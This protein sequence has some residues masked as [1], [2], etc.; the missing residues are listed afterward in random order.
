MALDG[1]Y[2]LVLLKYNDSLPALKKPCRV[3]IYS[4]SQYFVNAMT[5]GWIS[6]WRRRGWRKAD[7]QPAMNRDLWI[8]LLEAAVLPR[9]EL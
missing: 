7:G 9:S 1:H 6:A 5:K 4:D 3:S 2:G 8:R